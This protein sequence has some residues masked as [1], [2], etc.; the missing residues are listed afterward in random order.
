MKAFDSICELT[1]GMRYDAALYAITCE[2]SSSEGR[3][4]TNSPKANDNEGPEIR[5][6]TQKEVDEH[7]K[8]FVTPLTRLLEYLI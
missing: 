8:R 5:A 3:P 2:I 4:A 7:I 1:N 6:L